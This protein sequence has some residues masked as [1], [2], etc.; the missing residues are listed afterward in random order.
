MGKRFSE[1][2]A[3]KIAGQA[4]KRDQEAAKNRAERERIEAEELLKWEE[5]ARQP[6]QKKLLEEQKRQEKLQAKKERDEMLA[7]EEATLA[8]GGKGKK[9]GKK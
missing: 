3:K 5:G 4:R 8:K 2:A 1:S 6:N 7:A 9:N